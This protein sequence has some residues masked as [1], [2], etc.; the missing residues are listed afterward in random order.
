MLTSAVGTLAPADP[1]R[2][3]RPRTLHFID[4]ETEAQGGQET[5]LGSILSQGTVGPGCLA[6]NR[7]S[8]V[9]IGVQRPSAG[10]DFLG[11]GGVTSL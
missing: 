1:P 10:H 2:P 3:R 9:A 4:G 8:A 7:I 5:P 6:S 11:P